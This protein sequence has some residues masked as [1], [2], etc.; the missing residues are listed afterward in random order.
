MKKDKGK[1][2]MVRGRWISSSSILPGL[3]VVSFESKTES[4]SSDSHFDQFKSLASKI[5]AVTKE[6]IKHFCPDCGKASELGQACKDCRDKRLAAI[7]E[8]RHH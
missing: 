7:N 5:V 6:E 4:T 2:K 8:K 1:K 3:E